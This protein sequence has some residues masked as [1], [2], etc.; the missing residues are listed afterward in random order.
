MYFIPCGC[1]FTRMGGGAE[2]YLFC[3]IYFEDEKE[4]DNS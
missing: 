3:G 2:L 1:G 4:M